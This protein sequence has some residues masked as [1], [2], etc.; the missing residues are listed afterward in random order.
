VLHA[1]DKIGRESQQNDDL[2]R[3][4]ASLRELL[5]AE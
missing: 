4:L 3:E 2:R 1:C 5:Y